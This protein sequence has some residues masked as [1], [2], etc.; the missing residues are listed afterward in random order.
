MTDPGTVMTDLQD[1]TASLDVA[2]KALYTLQ[3]QY[4][5]VE[6]EYDDLFN[7]LLVALL[8]RYENGERRL[9]GEDVRN[10][11]VIKQIRDEAPAL[12]G[13]HRRLKAELDRGERRAKRIE[14]QI[15]SLQSL[16]S[17]LKTEAQATQ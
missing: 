6:E 17:M 8:A 12:Y 5:A 9:P 11:L 10:A 7:D 2:S 15:S 16:L 13:R 4:Q 14:R 3:E 1:R